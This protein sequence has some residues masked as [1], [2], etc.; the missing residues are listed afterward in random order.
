MSDIWVKSRWTRFYAWDWVTN[1][2]AV[3]S[4]HEA[5]MRAQVLPQSFYYHVL[6]IAAEHKASTAVEGNVRLRYVPRSELVP[7]VLAACRSPQS[8]QSILS[9]ISDP[10]MATR[11]QIL[12]AVQ[13][14]IRAGL[15]VKVGQEETFDPSAVFQAA[16]I[17]YGFFQLEPEMVPAIQAVYALR[18]KVV[19]EIGTAWGGSL[20]CWAQA[21]DPEA[22]LVSVDIP[23]GVGGGGYL[24][25][26][27][28][29]F[30]NFCFDTQHLVSVI[31][32]SRDPSVI[33]QVHDA[34]G[35]RRIDLLFIDG[36]HSYRGVKG[37][38]ECYGPLVSP[39]GV[40]MFHDIQPQTSPDPAYLIEVA[41][42]WI[43]VSS[44]RRSRSFV[45]EADQSGGGIGVVYM[46]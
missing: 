6:R 25:E 43:E 30:K 39:G 36:D 24:A 38:F 33:R 2:P 41:A 15:L 35:G 7:C 1:R 42:F 26:S 23:G 20:F 40:V 16:R 17:L 46:A 9:G 4:L 31:G 45:A 14:L 34:L 12:Q 13:A 8:I 22:L 18:P 32:D 21:A 29:H 5:S 10:S 37:D 19:V 27:V 44:T 11:G 3:M 28:P